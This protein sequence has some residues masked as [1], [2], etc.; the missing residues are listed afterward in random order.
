[1]T[2]DIYE[3]EGLFER[4]AELSPY[5]LDAV[6][7][8][9]DLDN[10]TDIR[11]YGLLAGFDVAPGPIPGLRGQDIMK[12]LF[13]AGVY[14]KFTGDSGLLAPPFISEKSDIDDIC[15]VIRKVLESA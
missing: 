13:A 3:K 2:L 8:L 7:A 1:M 11:G 4:A 5:F 6:F 10:V 9:Q 15:A 12:W 14:V